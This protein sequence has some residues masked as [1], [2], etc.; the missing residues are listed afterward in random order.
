[1]YF[2][3]SKIKCWFYNKIIFP[4]HRVFVI[5]PLHKKWAK[6]TE[7][8]HKQLRDAYSTND[9]KNIYEAGIKY[10]EALEAFRQQNPRL[11]S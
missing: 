11:F 8:E 9:N 3:Y 1:M 2:T 5:Y 10:N 4:I 7:K 6:A